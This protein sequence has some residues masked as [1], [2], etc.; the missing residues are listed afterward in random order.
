MA[1][2]RARLPAPQAFELQAPGDEH[3]YYIWNIDFQKTAADKLSEALRI[4]E[5][6]E[7]ESQTRAEKEHMSARSPQGGGSPKPLRDLAAGSE[8]LEKVHQRHGKNGKPAEIF[9]LRISSVS[10][11]QNDR[12]QIRPSPLNRIK[13]GH[14]RTNTKKPWINPGL[15]V[16]EG[17]FEPPK[18]SPADLQSVPFGHSGIPPY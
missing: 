14:C 16:G 6:A 4:S 5:I 12:L 11:L 13:T 8:H 1:Q 18:A 17:G 10:A 3:Y 15:L 7:T 9:D 2:Q